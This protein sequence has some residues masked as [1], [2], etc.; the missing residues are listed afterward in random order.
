MASWNQRLAHLPILD[1]VHVMS[2]ALKEPTMVL[3][4]SVI[5]RCFTI[6]NV[7]TCHAILLNIIR[8]VLENGNDHSTPYLLHNKGAKTVYKMFP[9]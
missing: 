5:Q 4:A 8:H 6:V 3:K 2:W 7:F 9:S 1:Y